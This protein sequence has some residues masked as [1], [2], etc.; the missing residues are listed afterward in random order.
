MAVIEAPAPP[1]VEL[2][3][4]GPRPM[5][6]HARDHGEQVGSVPPRARTVPARHGGVDP[7]PAAIVNQRRARPPTRATE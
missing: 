4:G 2:E 5:Q 1:R 3:D 6:V 7:A